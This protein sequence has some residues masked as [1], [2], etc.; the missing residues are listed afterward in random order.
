M[1]IV[2][3]E[4]F[5]FFKDYEI[6]RLKNCSLSQMKVQSNILIIDKKIFKNS[7]FNI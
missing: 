5:Y 1:A 2:I 7:Y 4:I 6:E 3:F